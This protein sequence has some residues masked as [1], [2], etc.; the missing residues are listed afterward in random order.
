MK[1]NKQ[2]TSEPCKPSSSYRLYLAQFELSY[3]RNSHGQLM[4]ELH[5]K[6]G[7]IVIVV[8]VVTVAALQLQRCY[9]LYI[10]MSKSH[11][12]NNTRPS[13]DSRRGRPRRP[14]KFHGGSG[15]SGVVKGAPK[16]STSCCC[17]CG[18]EQAKYKCPQCREPY[19]GIVCCRTHKE[20]DCRRGGGGG[21]GVVSDQQPVAAVKKSKYLPSDLLTRDPIENAQRKRK[22]LEDGAQDNNA[23]DEEDLEVGWKITE[24]MMNEMDKSAW[25]RTE[26]QDGGLRQLIWDVMSASKSVNRSGTATHQEELLQITSTKYP[27]FRTFLDKLKVLAGVLER[28]GVPG[29]GDEDDDDLTQWLE[30]EGDD[31]GPLALKPQWC[32]RDTSGLPPLP[33]NEDTSDDESSSAL[34]SDDSASSSSSSSGVSSTSSDSGDE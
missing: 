17:E 18:M 7:R 9:Q 3:G 32:S 13:H 19:C 21:G 34:S 16:S 15:K 1:K 29:G 5:C 20:K 25:L 10:D 33:T 11:G 12:I 14:P 8:V 6:R 24:E 30:Q 4:V 31:L 22:Q 27:H 28:Q 2:V 26:L 23:S